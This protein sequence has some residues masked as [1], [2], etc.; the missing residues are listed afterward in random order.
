MRKKMELTNEDLPPI[1]EEIEEVEECE[2]E[3][4]WRSIW[5]EQIYKDSSIACVQT[6]EIKNNLYSPKLSERMKN[7]LHLLPLWSHVSHKFFNISSDSTVSSATVD[8]LKLT[9]FNDL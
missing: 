5:L 7:V 4:K 2:P 8:L 6:G 9:H 1:N 3:Q